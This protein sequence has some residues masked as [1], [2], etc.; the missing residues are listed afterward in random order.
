[1]GLAWIALIIIIYPT[2]RPA[3]QSFV[4]DILAATGVTSG[5]AYFIISTIPI[6]ALFVAI[7]GAIWII[8]KGVR[9]EGG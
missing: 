8:Y 7:G 6:W 2:A 4:D 9:K 1:M 3:I 5:F